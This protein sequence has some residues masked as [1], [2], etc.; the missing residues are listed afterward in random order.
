MSQ[1]VVTP[2]ESLPARHQALQ[3]SKQLFMQSSSGGTCQKGLTP[4][5]LRVTPQRH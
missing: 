4:R 2:S 3:A 5:F 1:L